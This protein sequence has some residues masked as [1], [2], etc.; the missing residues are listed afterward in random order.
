MDTVLLKRNRFSNVMDFCRANGIV[1]QI[2]KIKVSQALENGVGLY[3][4]DITAD[5][6]EVPGDVVLNRNDVFIPFS[7]GVLLTFDD[8]VKPKGKARLYSYAPMAG[9]QNPVG[10]MTT[11]IE[12]LYNGIL[13][14]QVDQTAIMQSFPMEVLKHIGE[15]EPSILLNGSDE[16][17]SIGIQG[18][19][20]IEKM[21]HYLVPNIIYQGTMDIKTSVK[22][23]ATGSK[24][25]VALASDPTSAATDKTARISLFMDGILI[26]NGAFDNIVNG[27]SAAMAK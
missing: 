4:F 1:P 7:L 2:S 6:V 15:T 16:E 25:D 23:E 20:D 5:T 11:D 13:T 18:E 10:F 24:F 3:D 9:V 21:T 19:F 27:L 14:Q 12:G 26:K 17:V 8:K 22:F